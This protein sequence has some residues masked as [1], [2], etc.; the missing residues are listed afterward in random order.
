MKKL[1]L[2]IGLLALVGCSS[3]KPVDIA[4]ACAQP[5]NTPVVVQGFLSLPKTIDTIRLSRGG[6]ITDVGYQIFLANKADASGDSVKVTIWTTNNGEP[7]KIKAFASGYTLS[8]LIVYTDGG[9]P[10]GAGK[11]VRL[12]GTTSSDPNTGCAVD[13]T[14]IEAQ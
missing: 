5:E 13:V 4:D 8:D 1:L 12:T 2:L 3:P 7:N 10:V 9:A 6:R 11:I 14:K